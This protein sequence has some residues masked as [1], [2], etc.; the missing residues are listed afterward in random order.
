LHRRLDFPLW[1]YNKQ[2]ARKERSSLQVDP[3]IVQTILHDNSMD[4]RTYEIA[5]QM[6]TEQ[7]A[8]LMT[9][10]DWEVFDLYERCLDVFRAVT[11][12]DDNSNICLTTGPI[13]LLVLT[14]YYDLLTNILSGNANYSALVTKAAWWSRNGQKITGLGTAKKSPLPGR[15]GPY[16]PMALGSRHP[17]GYSLARASGRSSLT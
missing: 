8:A 3:S 2:R 6:F 1:L 10:L 4:V 16:D 7:F 17:R 11:D 13:S 12:N 15:H 5:C 9:P 14:V